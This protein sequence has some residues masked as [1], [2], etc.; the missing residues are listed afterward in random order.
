MKG[1]DQYE[2]RKKLKM[3]H[4]C[5][6]SFKSILVGNEKKMKSSYSSNHPLSLLLLLLFHYLGFDEFSVSL[7]RYTCYYFNTK[8]YG[9]QNIA[10]S[11]SCTAKTL[12]TNR[13]Y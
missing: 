11:Y 7:D 9:S 1:N 4:R 8:L 3:I 12:A 6:Y 2:S 13:H 10:R 5:H